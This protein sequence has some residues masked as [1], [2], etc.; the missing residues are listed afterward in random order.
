[1]PD[2]SG[3]PTLHRGHHDRDPHTFIAELQEALNEEMGCDL[4]V[5]GIFGEET[6][7]QVFCFQGKQNIEVDG[8]VG[9]ITW[10][11]LGWV[12]FMPPDEETPE[13]DDWRGEYR[14]L[15][16]RYQMLMWLGAP[17]FAAVP[18]WTSNR[19]HA[20]TGSGW[21]GPAIIAAVFI[22]IWLM[23]G[24]LFL[25]FRTVF[26]GDEQDEK[27]TR[28]AHIAEQELAI[29]R[30]ERLRHARERLHRIEDSKR[31]ASMEKM[32]KEVDKIRRSLDDDPTNDR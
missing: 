1:M 10:S 7:R 8:H 2:H 11:R 3:L 4:A 15:L 32:A 21:I 14:K 28:L 9:A 6:E 23:F 13:I 22:P 29:R 12:D 24:K 30:A 17:I 25:V 20:I 18:I 5:D 26:A 19:D 16:M 31:E 27:R